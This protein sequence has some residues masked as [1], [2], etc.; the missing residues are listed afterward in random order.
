MN[1]RNTKANRDRFGC[2]VGRCFI[3]L[4]FVVPVIL[5]LLVKSFILSTLFIL[6]NLFFIPVLLILL[7]L[8]EMRGKTP[9][10]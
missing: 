10:L 3:K 5:D 6:F 1:K 8:F 7:R 9:T 4:N 2:G